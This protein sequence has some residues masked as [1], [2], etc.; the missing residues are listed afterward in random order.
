MPQ[1]ARC[2]A[3]AKQLVKLYILHQQLR[4]QRLQRR[5]GLP[6]HT[7]PKQ[8]NSNLFSEPLPRLSPLPS[9]EG[10]DLGES[11]HDD[12]TSSSSASWLDEESSDDGNGNIPDADGYG[13]DDEAELSS[14][15]GSQEPS[16]DH[17]CRSQRGTIP[18]PHTNRRRVGGK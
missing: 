2:A 1:P 8:P 3:R 7:L 10:S 5:Q 16:G 18:T 4:K 17:P 11:S 6:D 15:G 12:S 13:G 9:A 14:H